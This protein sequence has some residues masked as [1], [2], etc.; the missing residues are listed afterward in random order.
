MAEVE[1]QRSKV[2]I[3]DAEV[4]VRTPGQGST[5]ADAMLVV[6]FAGP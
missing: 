2:R 6:A 3:T 5:I 1:M 4:E